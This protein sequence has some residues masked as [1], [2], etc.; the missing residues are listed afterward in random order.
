ML[1]GVGRRGQQ[2]GALDALGVLP[3]GSRIVRSNIGSL[4]L[5]NAD[6]KSLAA[7]MVERLNKQPPFLLE[8]HAC[9]TTAASSYQET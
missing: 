7:R 5:R 8:T 2:V 9:A 1:L 6:D 3:P 4:D